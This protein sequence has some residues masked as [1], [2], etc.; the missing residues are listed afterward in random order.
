[1]QISIDGDRIRTRA[2]LEQAA[3]GDIGRRVLDAEPHE[4]AFHVTQAQWPSCQQTVASVS[5]RCAACGRSSLLR[6]RP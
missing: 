1:M 4:P 3:N 6:R 2:R 5:Q